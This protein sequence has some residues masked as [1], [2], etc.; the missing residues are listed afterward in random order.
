[1]GR[2]CVLGKLLD[3]PIYNTTQNEARLGPTVPGIKELLPEGEGVL[4]V[5]KTAF[6]M[7]REPHIT[8]EVSLLGRVL[9][10]MEGWWTVLARS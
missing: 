5:N 3:I 1:M 9:W 6:S 4:N 8:H 10:L 2:L 7:V